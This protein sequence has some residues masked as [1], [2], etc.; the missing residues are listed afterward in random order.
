[1]TDRPTN[2]RRGAIIAG[3]GANALDADEAADLTLLTDALG[4]PSTWAE[5][6]PGLEDSVARAVGR[7]EPTTTTP[8]SGR[9][10][11]SQRA[12]RPARRLAA[13]AAA[14]AIAVVALV[15]GTL[16]VTGHDAHPDFS[17]RLTATEL[18][19]GA[20]GS[21]DIAQRAEGFRVKLET[22]DLPLLPSNE[23]YQA[24]LKNADGTLVSIGS[25]SKSGG[26][27]V[28]LWSGVSPVDFNTITVTIETADN[29]QA[30]SGRRVLVGTVHAG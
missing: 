23:Y 27:Y 7:A 20:H 29:V 4:D 30:S 6:A 26:G 11:G 5:P 28:T 18:A 15:G 8:E 16:A 1:M 13:L 21:A 12:R 9:A 2:E 25:F 3:F 24:W 19:P 14:A 22:D 17:A 10:H